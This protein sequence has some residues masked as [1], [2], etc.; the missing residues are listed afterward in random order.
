M[1]ES[2]DRYYRILG[3]D[4]GAPK[5]DIK[6][7]YRKLALRYHPDK[8]PD[9]QERATRIFIEINKAYSILMDKPGASEP[10]EDVADA[11]LYFKRH[12]Y[13]L[14]RRINNADHLSAGIYQEECDF[15]FRYQL[16]EVRYVR[17]S[18][19]EAR[20]IIDM[21]RKA[22]SKGY[23]TS[24]I[25]RDHSDF[26]QKHGFDRQPKYDNYEELVTEYKM[27]VADEP[28]N[29]EAHY[30]LG[31]IYERQG[32]IDDAISEYQIAYYIDPGTIEAKQAVERLRKRR[33]KFHEPT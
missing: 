16:E 13:D 19:V 26:F 7:A 8:N 15:F 6:R 20:R 31:Y 3:L 1:S 18:A 5:Q 23:D 33:R 32:K 21:V 22:I 2:I 28:C 25:L 4:N 12:F 17:R 30:S 11:R 29:A 10:I 24:A 14:A 27:I 9:N